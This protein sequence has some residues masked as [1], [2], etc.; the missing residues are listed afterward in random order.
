MFQISLEQVYLVYCLTWM[1]ALEN[2]NIKL[3]D[4]FLTEEEVHIFMCFF[5]KEKKKEKTLRLNFELW[6]GYPDTKLIWQPFF[7]QT[8]DQPSHQ[9]RRNKV[10]GRDKVYTS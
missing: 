2:Q 6:L 8:A 3:V 5:L 7:G 1:P 10:K 4:T 9:Y